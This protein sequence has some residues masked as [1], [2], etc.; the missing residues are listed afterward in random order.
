MQQIP[1]LVDGSLSVWESHSIVRYLASGYSPDLHLDSIEG[2]AQCS[3]WMDWALFIDFHECNCLILDQT[4]RTKPEDRDMGNILR[5]Y[6]G[7]LER[8]QKVEQ[9]LGDTGGFLAGERFSI[10]DIPVGVEV[11]RFSCCL[12]RCAL[13]GLLSGWKLP[14]LPNLAAT[15][16]PLLGD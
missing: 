3:P 7:Y 9:R 2:M 13:D 12:E 5:G 14:S 4:A 1:C 8:F 11:C 15:R 16:L 6:E 10:A